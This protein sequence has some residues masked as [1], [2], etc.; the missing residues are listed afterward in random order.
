MNSPRFIKT[1]ERALEKLF[2]EADFTNSG[3]LSYD[4]FYNAFKRLPTYELND[5]DFKIM[6]GLADEN[7]NGAISWP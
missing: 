4:Q 6:L 7:E 3:E 1:L 5:N 2:Q